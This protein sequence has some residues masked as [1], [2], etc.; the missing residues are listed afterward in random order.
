MSVEN[1]TIKSDQRTQDLESGE[2]HLTEM[3]RTMS[4]ELKK[5]MPLI[6][7]IAAIG[8]SEDIRNILAE[9]AGNPPEQPAV[10][11]EHLQLVKTKASELSAVILELIDDKVKTRKELLGIEQE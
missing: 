5:L 9:R 6:Q 3:A 4:N 2:K 10:L 11:E 7:K 1:P 8:Y